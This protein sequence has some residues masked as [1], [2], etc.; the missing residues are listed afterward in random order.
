MMSAPHGLSSPRPPEA[1]R[2]SAALA[3]AWRWRGSHS[4]SCRAAHRSGALRPP[5]R[6][7]AASVR[8]AASMPR[9]WMGRRA[10]AL[11]TRRRPR[12]SPPGSRAAVPAR[13]CSARAPRSS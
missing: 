12:L 1:G 2:R 5:T 10:P 11:R 13:W 8:P 4:A 7:S 3:V 6:S 9:G